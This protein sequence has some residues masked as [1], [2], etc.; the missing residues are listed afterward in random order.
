MHVMPVWH[1]IGGCRRVEPDIVRAV[2]A[3]CE[4]VCGHGLIDVLYMPGWLGP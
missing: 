4:P 3:C 2:L 1:C